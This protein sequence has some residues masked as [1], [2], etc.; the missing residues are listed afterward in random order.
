MRFDQSGAVAQDSNPALSDAS[1]E[2]KRV[3]RVGV[4][5]T[6]GPDA[7]VYVLHAFLLIMK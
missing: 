5:N 6:A 2:K 7:D 4:V 1:G 3:K